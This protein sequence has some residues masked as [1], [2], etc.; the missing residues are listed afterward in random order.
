MAKHT[1]VVFQTIHL[2][3]DLNQVGIQSTSGG[4]KGEDKR[5]RAQKSRRESQSKKVRKLLSSLKQ[6]MNYLNIC[7]RCYL[8]KD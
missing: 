1:L 7:F 3:M 6:Q 4:K 5:T 8:S 2:L